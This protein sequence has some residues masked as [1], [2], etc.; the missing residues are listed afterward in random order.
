[1]KC[2][3]SF[4]GDKCPV[5]QYFAPDVMSGDAGLSRQ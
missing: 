5:L 3:A 1:M 4:S 2:L